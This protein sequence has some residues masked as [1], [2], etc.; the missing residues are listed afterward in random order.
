M[1]LDRLRPYVGRVLHPFVLGFD[2]LGL[3][4]DAASVLALFAAI[5]AAVAFAAG[6]IVATQWYLLAAGLV[7]ANGWLDL[8]DGA[9]ARH[10]GVESAAGDLLDHALDRYADVILIAGIA[11]G[12]TA[13]ALGLAAVTGVLLTSYMGTQAQAVGLER[14]YG[15]VVGRA[16]RLAI[17]GLA[18]V[19]AF[20]VTG[21]VEGLTVMEWLLVL[22]AVVG[23]FTA[24]QRFVVSY[25]RL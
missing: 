12:E 18:G 17:I 15:G 23:H 5:T 4:P 3:G 24:L 20:A 2:R 1:T 16:D 9:L 10:Q 8:I 13:W 25:R 11:A 21:T 22:L 14:V 19:L 7:F 6:G